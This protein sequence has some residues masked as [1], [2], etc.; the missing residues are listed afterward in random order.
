[1]NQTKFSLSFNEVVNERHSVRQYVTDHQ[2]PADD[3]HEILK[4]AH[5]APSLWNLQHWRVIVVQDPQNKKA[6]LPIAYNQQ[7]VVDSSAIFVILGDLEAHKTGEAAFLPLVDEG[8]MPQEV[9]E[10]TLGDIKQAYATQNAYTQNQAFL[11]S[12]LFAM[13]LMLA[14]KS[15][16]YD[17]GP[18]GGFDPVRLAEA[19]NIPKRFVPVM[20]ISMGIASSPA[21]KTTRLP[22]DKI[23]VNES[24]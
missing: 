5:T 20:M 1:M 17:T 3:L 8:L 10:K 7:Q 16:G 4:L 6:L 18:M 22:L 15:K 14:A 19:L 9:Y 23:V 21:F 13:Q 2:I 11:N 24:F 12:A